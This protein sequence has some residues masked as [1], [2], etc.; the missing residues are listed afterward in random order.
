[1]ENVKPTH[2]ASSELYF[3]NV[4]EE[5]VKE[6]VTRLIEHIDM[7]KCQRCIYDACAI[8]LNALNPKYVTTTKGAL[9]SQVG[10]INLDN[11]TEIDVQVIKALKIVKEHPRHDTD[12]P[13]EREKNDI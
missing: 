2:S 9:L 4:M 5:V 8:T 13:I 3:T 12:S 10:Y 7:C 1:M 6:R 11:R